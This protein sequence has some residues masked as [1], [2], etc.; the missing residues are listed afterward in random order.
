MRS[1]SDPMNTAAAI[2][3]ERARNS[4][5]FARVRAS[6]IDRAVAAVSSEV[7][8]VDFL[9]RAGGWSELILRILRE[10]LDREGLQMRLLEWTEPRGWIGTELCHEVP[11]MRTEAQTIVARRCTC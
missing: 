2:R 7:D 8:P 6:V 11:A 5:E 4:P 9:R 3:R 10:E 1:T